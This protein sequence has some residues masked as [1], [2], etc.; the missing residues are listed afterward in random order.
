MNSNPLGDWF[1]RAFVWGVSN[2]AVLAMWVGMISMFEEISN[3]NSGFEAAMT[4]VF[5]LILVGLPIVDSRR[6]DDWQRLLVFGFDVVVTFISMLAY[7][8]ASIMISELA[9]VVGLT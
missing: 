2:G 3:R 8:M 1:E 9:S 7:V 5:C 6:Y 4:L